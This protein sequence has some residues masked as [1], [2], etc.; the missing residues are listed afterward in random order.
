MLGIMMHI[1][2]SWI[3]GLIECLKE[4]IRNFK[5]FPWYIFH[6]E[7][8]FCKR[9]LNLGGT[10]KRGFLKMLSRGL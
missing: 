5:K 10:L 8:I 9:S 4:G 1:I 6:F 3:T 7:I 2:A